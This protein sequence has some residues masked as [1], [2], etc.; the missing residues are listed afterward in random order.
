MAEANI[1]RACLDVLP[2]PAPRPPPYPGA[3]SCN[4]RQV[5]REVSYDCSYDQTYDCS[6]DC[7]FRTEYYDCGGGNRCW[8]NGDCPSGATCSCLTCWFCGWSGCTCNNNGRC[9]RGRRALRIAS[10]APARE[11]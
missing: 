11:S 8:G 1:F 9:G 2:N 6:Y 3:G 10:P 4:C 7:N 5:P